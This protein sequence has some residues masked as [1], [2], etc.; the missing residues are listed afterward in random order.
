M[1]T[2]SV[3][4]TVLP[5]CVNFSPPLW[6]ICPFRPA[7]VSVPPVIGKLTAPDEV[8]VAGETGL[9][10]TPAFFNACAVGASSIRSVFLPVTVIVCAVARRSGWLLSSR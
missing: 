8:A 2:K 1:S 5:E 3:A 10:C 7:W 9:T 6:V 4:V